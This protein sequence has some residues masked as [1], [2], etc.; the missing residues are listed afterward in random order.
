MK[1]PGCANNRGSPPYASENSSYQIP[2][3]PNAPAAMILKAKAY[4]DDANPLSNRPVF[5]FIHFYMSADSPENG[6]ITKQIFATEPAMAGLYIHMKPES[7][8]TP[9]MLD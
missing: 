5:K 3:L 4:G 2:L 7:K 8:I 1:N 9:L 6:I